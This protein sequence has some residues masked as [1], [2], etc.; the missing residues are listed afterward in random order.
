VNRVTGSDAVSLADAGEVL[1][2]SVAFTLPND[3]R[4]CTTAVARGKPLL[5][6]APVSR[7][8]KRYAEL[9]EQLLPAGIVPPAS[10]TLPVST[11]P[12]GAFSR[13]FHLGG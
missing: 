4:N 8:A 1:E 5:E 12:A 7:L 13:F 2:R 3:H 6:I 11:R 10:A 9:A